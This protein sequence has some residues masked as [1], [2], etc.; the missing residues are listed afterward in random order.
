MTPLADKTCTSKKNIFPGRDRKNR[1][2]S[3]NSKNHPG[4]SVFFHILLHLPGIADFCRLKDVSA[5]IIISLNYYKKYEKDVLSI[6]PGGFIFRD[7][8]Q[9]LP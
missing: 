9:P 7:P 1:R 5:K 8:V 6:A 2:E 4:D 3:G